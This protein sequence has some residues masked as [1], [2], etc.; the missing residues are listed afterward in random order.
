MKRHD[1]LISLTLAVV[2]ACS[3]SSNSAGPGSVDGGPGGPG[4]VDAAG[5]G[6][7]DGG[8]PGG[9]DGG[10]N[11]FVIPK[12]DHVRFY[13]RAGHAATMNGG[14][15]V[16]SN[17]SSTNGF[18]DIATIA[19]AP[20]EGQWTDLALPA[21]TPYRFVKFYGA[22]GSNGDVAEI[23]FSSGGAGVT[24]TP[25]GTPS[26]DGKTNMPANAFDGDVTT[27]YDGGLADNQ[28]VGLDLAGTHV[29]GVTVLS[30]APGRFT[31]AVTVTITT[32]TAGATIKYTTDGTDPAQG[33]VYTAP[34][35]V[36]QTS[37]VRAVAQAPC[38]LDSPI[39]ES[40]YSIG[41]A[42]KTAQS[43]IHVGNSLTGTIITSFPAVAKTGNMQLAFN[44]CTSAGVSLEGMWTNP[45][46]CDNV[47]PGAVTD[48][49]GTLM[50][51]PFDNL[52]L[53]PFPFSPCTPYGTGG[54]AAYVNDFYQLAKA[55]N[56]DVQVWVYA[57][58]PAP[59]A[60]NWASV[61]CFA[62][63]SGPTVSPPKWTPPAVATDWESATMNHMAYYEAVRSGVD[64]LNPGGK[65]ALVVPVGLGLINLKHAIEAG[66]VHDVATNAF[67]TTVFNNNGADLHTDKQGSYLAA[68]IFYSAFFQKSPEG[69]PV[70]TTGFGVTAAEGAD[71]QRIAWQTVLNYAY[72]GLR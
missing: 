44:Y 2:A 61:D 4:S 53:Q 56:P 37:I 62:G 27:F 64:A 68:L 15:F 58:W 28:Y 38:M 21:T 67:F 26:A 42:S 22:Q 48:L 18:V 13:P 1:S 39:T 16:G 6:S 5:P 72:G 25:F 17:E 51:T 23:Q 8:A 30:P 66:Q 65:K 63:G 59:T 41:A 12:V 32:P 69:L 9:G 70:D 57:T 43:S 14:K 10:A 71:F 34:F 11:C 20:P 60:T 19:A 29:A 47:A 55:K 24:G 7:A 31:S 45:P 35:M 52:A 49:K 40:L 46:G 36:S 54:E 3:S 33:T 50:S